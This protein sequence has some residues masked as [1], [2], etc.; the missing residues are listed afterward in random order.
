MWIAVGL[1]AAA[2]VLAAHAWRA[3]GG[4][5]VLLVLLGGTL[6]ALGVACWMGMKSK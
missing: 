6:V 4:G 1:E 5:A 2:L 3:F